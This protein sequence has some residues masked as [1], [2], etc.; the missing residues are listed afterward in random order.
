MALR[1]VHQRAAGG[2]QWDGQVACAGAVAR[3]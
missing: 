2:R 1:P 3:Q